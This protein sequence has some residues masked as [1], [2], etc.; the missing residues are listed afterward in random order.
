MSQILDVPVLII[1]GGPVGL[2][3]GIEL[4][5]RGVESLLIEQ[6]GEMDDHPKIGTIV[7][8]T[9]EFFRRWGVAEDVIHC[10]FPL[11]Y[12][13]SIAFCTS[14]AGY[15]LDKDSYPSTAAA[16]LPAGSPHKR[17]RCPQIWLDPI[18]RQAARQR[19]AVSLKLR[20]RLLGF[21]QSEKGVTA[22]VEALESGEIF[23]VRAAY[24]IGCDGASSLVRNGL[25]ITMQGNPKLN[26]SVG[27]LIR[28]PGL[29]AASKTGEI[30]RVIF[31]GPE[32]TWGNLT[33]VDGSE[34]WR[35][36]IYGA[37]ERIRMEDFDAAS[38]VQRALGRDDLAFEIVA[39]VPWR[40]TELVASA[41]R[42][43][44]VFLAGDACHTMSPTG[45]MGVNTG[46]GD[47]V[48]LGWKI[49]AVLEGWGGETLL[50]SYEQERRPIALRNAAFSTHNFKT[51]QTPI[52]SAD[53]EKPG[54]EG[55]AI[56]AAAGSALKENTKSDWQSWGIQLGY[57]YENSP[58]IVPDN[59]PA[60][61]DDYTTFVQTARPGHRLP[62]VWLAPERSSLDLS[63]R[64][65]VLLAFPDA[66]PTGIEAFR[67]AAQHHGVP[68]AV[69]HVDDANLAALC[70]APLVLV[71][72]DDHVAW[73]GRGSDDPAA[74]FGIATGQASQF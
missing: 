51:W 24:L 41:Y 59:T 44:R 9:M 50:D 10:G 65:F 21:S 64:G 34:L 27:I 45:G 32:G 58:I 57:R 18:L 52:D 19:K 31:V 61:A 39:I 28:C 12:E 74:I 30:E 49:G 38:W 33:V 1:G 56:R 70:A 14:M 66:A 22:S 60:P 63:G 48:D 62:H 23:T 40:R 16:P 69:E 15:V 47:V 11:D 35:V 72:P 46:F 29:I 6:N 25:G 54:P 36:T 73:R 68:L 17:H 20:H 4:A 2:A 37:D 42:D 8:R 7:T 71:R 53:I 26:Y 5:E 43:G 13:L 3:M 67:S 55:D